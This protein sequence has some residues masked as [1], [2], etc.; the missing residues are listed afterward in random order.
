M[1]FKSHIATQV[2]GS[3]GGT[4]FASN[5][6]GMYM[7]A[8]STP[9]NPNSPFQVA[10]RAGFRAC[11]NAWTN[12]LTA[13]QRAAWK[14]Y[15]ANTPLINSLGDAKPIGANAMFAR[16]NTV[17]QQAG[18]SIQ[19]SAPTTFD[20]GSF[21]LPT[22]SAAASGATAAVT[23]TTGDSWHATG[24]K[25]LIGVSRSQ[26]GSIEFFKGPFRFAAAIDG[27]AT[28]PATFT[29]PFTAGGTTNNMFYHVSALQPDGR[30]SEPVI[31]KSPPV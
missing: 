7:R 17:R 9:T 16:T 29:L 8:R 12:V 13:A 24:G 18:L 2:S 1:K 21:T 31:I 11:M 26:N 27:A 15:A 20:L 28:S 5:Q 25:L 10:V 3:V 23:F 4:T 30:L 6:G 14:T 19:A 22:F